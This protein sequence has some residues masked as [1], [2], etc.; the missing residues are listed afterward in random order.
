M[1]SVARPWAP[2]S[3]WRAPALP[4][5]LGFLALTVLAFA[6]LVL[7][8]SQAAFVDSTGNALSRLGAG[9]WA[10][11]RD[12]DGGK[13]HQC[14][15]K[16]DGTAWCWGANDD[17]ELGDDTFTDRRLP[18]QVQ[19][20]GGVGVFTDG[21]LLG[22]G[23]DHTC[24]VRSDGTAWCWGRWS[25]GRLGS[26]ATS[27]RDTPQ[28]VRGP[29]GVGFLTGVADIE[30]GDD[31]TCARKTDG[32]VW[33]WGQG[34][35][36][37]I[38]DDATS[39]RTYPVQVHGVNGVGFLTDVVELS[40]GGDHNCARTSDGAVYCWGQGSYGQ[41]GNNDDNDVETP[42][43]VVGPGGSGWMIAVEISVGEDHTCARQSD[44][45]AWCWGRND[46]GRLG[47]D[48]AVDRDA[49]VQVVGSGGVGTLTS[50][51]R[52]STGEEHTCARRAD[53]SVWC[54]GENADGQ[55][56][57]DTFSDRRYPVQVETSSGFLTS[58]DFVGVG[59]FHSCAIRSSDEVWCW[60]KG[61]RGQIGNG[62]SADVDYAVQSSI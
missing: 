18:V 26:G 25:N 11:F 62:T 27:D 19:G 58:V 13:R 39:D 32:T 52:L 53:T 49:P 28:Q 9:T 55:L 2:V 47:D 23:W 8:P 16:S 43:R 57:D 36:G 4:R 38:G 37:Q 40:S 1:N 5:V 33:C 45:T 61:D 10:G 14:A 44:G 30:G 22:A 24:A 20:S 17:G 29:S 35:R 41:L 56:G 3:R 12:L 7:R 51:E 54:W 60:G 34:D 21:V 50:V 6:F 15:I 46:E 48:T 59:G 31:H 42:V